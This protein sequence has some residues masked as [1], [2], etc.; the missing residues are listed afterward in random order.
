MIEE[1]GSMFLYLP[2]YLVSA[3]FLLG[4]LCLDITSLFADGA[5]GLLLLLFQLFIFL[6]H[7]Q[8]R[9]KLLQLTVQLAFLINQVFYGCGGGAAG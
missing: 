2:D 9:I 6:C 4:K 8:H 1:I 7:L 5:F 3:V